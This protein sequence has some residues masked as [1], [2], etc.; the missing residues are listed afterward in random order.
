M[1]MISIQKAAIFSGMD[2][3]EVY[4]ALLFLHAEEKPFRKNQLIFHAG[5]KTSSMGLVLEGSVTI[6]SNDLW[7][8]RTILSHVASGQFFAETYALLKTEPMLVDVRANEKSR[9]LFLNIGNLNNTFESPWQAK[10]IRNLLMISSQKN[11]VLSGRSFHT[12]S[13]SIRG[14]VM[15]YL[16]TVSLQKKSTSFDIPFDRQQLADYLNVERS[17][18]S[19]ELGRMQR[20][21]IIATRKSHFEIIQIP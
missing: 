2:E 15:S 5:K 19:K 4:E 18:L 8:N 20:D 9:I 6:E 3:T 14:R 11:L 17:A 1:D 21:G 10:M 7:G 12:A 16:N 13:K